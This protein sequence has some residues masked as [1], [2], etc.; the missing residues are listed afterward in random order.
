MCSVRRHVL[1]AALV[2]TATAAGA[3]VRTGIAVDGLVGAG[4]AADPVRGVTF[5]DGTV[6]LAPWVIGADGRTSTVA[7]RLGLEARDELRGDLAMLFAYWTGLPAADWCRIDVRQGSAVMSSPTED[8]AHLLVVS[9][10][11]ELTRGSA[12]D[13]QAAYLRTLGLFPD[14]VDPADLARA[15]QT[16]DVVSVPETMLRGVRRDANGPGWA[17][18]GDAGLYKH[19]ATGQGISDAL[20]QGRHVAD[21]LVERGDLAGYQAWR[22]ARAAGHYEFSFAAGTLS[23]PGAAALYSGLAADPEATQEFLDVF[24]KVRLPHEVLSDERTSRWRAAWI[25]EQGLLEL[26]SLLDTL[27]DAD[28]DRP[29]PACPDWGVGDLLAHLVGIAADSVAGRFYDGALRAWREP[30]AAVARDEWTAGHVRQHARSGLAALRAELDDRGGGVVA[31]LRRGVPTAQGAPEW[32]LTAAVGDLCVHL[33]D[34]REALGHP[35]RPASPVTRWGFASF[36]G[37]LDQRLRETGLRAL[38]LTDGTREWLLGD[39]SPDGVVTADQ[40]E[41]YRMITGRRS[42]AR[43]RSYEWTTDPAPYLPVIAPYPLPA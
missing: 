29:V 36:R 9:G 30:S 40:H 20:A 1:D 38:V 43:I 14:V 11:A 8:E 4:T 22:D 13:R 28:L 35:P 17:L 24:T 33:A 16:G 7:R 6:A 37:W 34:L 10:P 5:A 31:A 21:A 27:V 26:S 42:A 3:E 19:P 12:A 41:L 15:S 23:S 25:Y 39:G 18:V 32:G 2:D